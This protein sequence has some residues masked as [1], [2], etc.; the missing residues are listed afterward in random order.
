MESCFPKRRK[1]SR[2]GRAWVRPRSDAGLNYAA[3]TAHEDVAMSA[4]RIQ[5]NKS[6]RV[7]AG[8]EEWAKRVDLAAALAW[9]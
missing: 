6:V 5:K 9:K 8:P 2:T 7:H 1:R 3:R 4:T